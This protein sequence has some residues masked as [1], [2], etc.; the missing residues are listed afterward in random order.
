MNKYK[1]NILPGLL[2]VMLVAYIW[3]I[4]LNSG[5]T[6]SGEIVFFAS[7]IILLVFCGYNL[8]LYI[9]EHKTYNQ[10]KTI[11]IVE[12][13]FLTII[14]IYG[15]VSIYRLVRGGYVFN[16]VEACFHT[17]APLSLALFIFRDKRQYKIWLKWINYAIT[18]INIYSAVLH[19][20]IFGYLRSQFLINVNMVAFLCVV[21]MFINGLAF[22]NGKK[23]VIN[24]AIF[25]F[26]VVYNV[27]V[28]CV[29]GSR[30]A[31]FMGGLSVISSAICLMK[32]ADVKYYIVAWI[33]AF[34]V[35]ST[36]WTVNFGECRYLMMRGF[37]I[38]TIVENIKNILPVEE[39]A[40][41]DIDK[42]GM[43]ADNPT[44][45]EANEM[46]S[47]GTESSIR[48]NHD[49]GKGNG[50][51]IENAEQGT[52]EEI[53][54]R[55]PE[56]I[57]SE[58]LV[59]ND[60]LR[61]SFWSAA[62][63]EIKKEPIFG[64]GK[65]GIADSEFGTQSA[66]NFVLEYCLIYGILGFVV[67]VVFVCTYLINTIKALNT[68]TFRKVVFGLFGLLVVTFGFSFFE[69]TLITT[70][71]SLVVWIAVFLFTASIFDDE[72]QM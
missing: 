6:N 37:N 57:V 36:M 38:T 44:V 9:K 29:V 41:E 46:T 67:W 48:E 21:D 4:R 72:E 25:V 61:F 56:Q 1:E 23:N 52:G 53:P 24:I 59:Q 19:V 40:E 71:G 31:A 30:A 22:R 60:Q 66:H 2:A 14:F 12:T 11:R 10:I 42:S 62:M 35:V 65:I 16:S 5:V 18:F 26:N 8:I 43:S 55:S 15:I 47:V 20:V 7:D 28:F 17:L 50:E 3:P 33:T 70:F 64:T 45:P 54:V 58:A 69:V 49:A 39:K 68:K 13:A 34:V 27:S 51:A 32:R 63:E